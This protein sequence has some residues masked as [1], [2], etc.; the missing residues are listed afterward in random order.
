MTRSA[1][2]KPAP[3]R[4]GSLPLGIL[5]QS[6]GFRLR[7][8]QNQMARAYVDQVGPRGVKTGVMTALSIIG[9]NPGIS[10]TELAREAGFDKA[11]IVSLV[12]ELE[13]LGWAQRV[14]LPSDRRRH[15]L[16]LTPAG[17]QAA[18]DLVDIATGIEA[19]FM[20]HL[21]AQ[22]RAQLI[23]TLDSIL[24]RCLDDDAT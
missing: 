11:S 15:A 6:I 4:P 8:I 22:D 24:A 18:I 19:Q 5:D 20:D 3:A 23:S 12:D 13:R 1:A 17:S 9:A 10:Q 14:R 16:S 7:R 21:S 2:R